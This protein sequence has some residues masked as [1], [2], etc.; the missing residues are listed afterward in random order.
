MKKTKNKEEWPLKK[1]WLSQ[2]ASKQTNKGELFL[3]IK[4]IILKHNNITY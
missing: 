2:L 3:T 1:E 4:H